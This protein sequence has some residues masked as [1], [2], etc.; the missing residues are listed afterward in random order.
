ML[1]GKEI[2]R[3]IKEKDLIKDFIDLKTQITSGG[4]DLT[5]NSVSTFDSKGALDF[6]NKERIVPEG[7][8]I[9][10]KKKNPQDNFGW[11]NL[12]KGAYKIKTNEVVSLTNDLTALAFPRSSLLRMGAF[13]QTAVWDA[14]FIGKSEFILIVDNPKGIELKQNARI[15]QLV[16]LKMNEAHQGYQGVYQNKE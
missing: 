6:S 1:N 9:P 8:E 16:F 11:W 15:V 3:L 12:K 7:K 13:T 14:G 5:V 10:P 4:F 2:E